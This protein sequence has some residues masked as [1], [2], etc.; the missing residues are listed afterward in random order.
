[1]TP[2]EIWLYGSLMHKRFLDYASTWNCLGMR[3]EVVDYR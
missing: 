1:M 3:R 2:C